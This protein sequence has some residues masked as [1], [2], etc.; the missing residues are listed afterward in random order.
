MKA[1]ELTNK[2]VR[3]N[4]QGLT[5]QGMLPLKRNSSNLPAIKVCCIHT[6]D[7]LALSF[8]LPVLS[9]TE[10]SRPSSN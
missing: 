5:L 2:K 3:I 6:L 7:T 10:L 1:S 4:S 8:L 9:P